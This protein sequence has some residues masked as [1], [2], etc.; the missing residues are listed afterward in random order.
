MS[1][2]PSTQSIHKNH[3]D[4]HDPSVRLVPAIVN[5]TV[6]DHLPP[7]VT[8]TVANLI[9]APDDEV[10]IGINFKSQHLGRKGV[11]KITDRELSAND[12]SRLALVAPQASMAIIRDY[13]VVSKSAI[14]IPRTIIDIARCPNPG[15]VTNHE[16]CSTRFSVEQESPLIVQCRYCERHFA[17]NE[18]AIITTQSPV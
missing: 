3:Q 5:G 12:L 11:V 17:G 10:L 8:L 9:A 18:L 2:Q 16:P 14:P 1:H 6:V 15:C 4:Q 13:Q 7:A